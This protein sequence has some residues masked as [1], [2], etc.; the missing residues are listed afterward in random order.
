M[1]GLVV[2]PDGELELLARLLYHTV[3][4]DRGWSLHLFKNDYVPN[5]DTELADL[6]EADY[7]GYARVDL[8]EDGWGE[9]DQ[10]A[11]AAVS[12]YG[13]DF[14]YFFTAAGSQLVYGYYLTFDSQTKLLWSQRF[15]VSPVSVSTT[16][17]AMV[18][19]VLTGRSQLEPPP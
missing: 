14:E 7:S 19:P 6:T 1:P 8:D 2:S 3:W 11:G 17:P 16:V 10:I 9:P 12:Y 18:W 13:T 15:D 4:V 5:R